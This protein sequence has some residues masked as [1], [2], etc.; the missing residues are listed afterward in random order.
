MNLIIGI[1]LLLQIIS[2]GNNRDTWLEIARGNQYD[3]VNK[4]GRNTDI[5][6]SAADEDIWFG[7]G[8]WV[9]PT[10]ARIHD[11][12]STS[13]SDDGDPAGV[14]AQTVRIWGLTSWSA[15]QV[16]ETITLNGQTNVPTANAYVIINRMMVDSSGSTSINV[17]EISATA[18]TD[19]TVSAVIAATVGQTQL[20]M[21]GIPSTKVGY[22]VGIYATVNKQSATSVNISL[23]V[24]HNPST[25]KNYVVK[26]TWGIHTQ[27]SSLNHKFQPYF[28]IPG[29]AIVLMRG[30]TSANNADVSAGYD[31]ILLNQ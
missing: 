14:G 8:V 17:G 2:G 1:S 11:I 29:P 20:T 23:R 21:Y 27:G 15:D 18:Q 31:M 28:Q 25:S 24:N 7:G 5:D 3:Y 9:K 10:T 26:N 4:F 13:A 30:S 6:S 19:S 12:V 22:M 16:S